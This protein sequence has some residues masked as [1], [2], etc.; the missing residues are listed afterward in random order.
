MHKWS[1]KKAQLFFFLSLSALFMLSFLLLTTHSTGTAVQ[2][3]PNGASRRSQPSFPTYVTTNFSSPLS[4]G[5]RVL[6]ASDWAKACTST[7]SYNGQS[8]LEFVHKRKNSRKDEQC[9]MFS[10]RWIYDNVSYPLQNEAGCPYMS[11]QLACTKH[12]RQDTEYQKWRWQPHDC[13]L[14]RWNGAEMWEKLRNKRLMFVGDSLNR[15]Q[16]IS[17]FDYFQGRGI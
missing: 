10:G 13:D 3:G 8:N 17:I 12:G 7:K 1:R 9:D 15:G 2:V 16:W 6:D 14:K 11:D 5:N 4:D